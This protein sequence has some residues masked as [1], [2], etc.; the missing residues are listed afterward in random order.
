MKATLNDGTVLEGQPGEIVEAIRELGQRYAQAPNA[1][2]NPNS[3][4][5]STSSSVWTEERVRSLWN[6]LY[7]KQKEF[8]RFLAQRGGK[9]SIQEVMK[10][11]S[12]HKSTEVAGLRS[13][14]TRNARRETGNKKAELIVWERTPKGEWHYK[15]VTD[16]LPHLR[17]LM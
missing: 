7:G 6:F 8:V 2:S 15:I 13:C 14:I 17:G 10:E 9:A 16:V 11:L 12:L 5:S 3:H 4:G 1:R